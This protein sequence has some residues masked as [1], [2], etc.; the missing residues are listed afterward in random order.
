[1]VPHHVLI[2]RFI[3]LIISEAYLFDLLT[4]SALIYYGTATTDQNADCNDKLGSSDEWTPLEFTDGDNSLEQVLWKIETVHAWVHKLR[5]QIDTVVSKNAAKFS[6]SENLSLLAPFDVQTSAAHSP[7]FSAGNGDTISAGAMY[8]STQHIPEYDIDMA[9]H[10]SVVSS[11]GEAIPVP[12]II[13]STV[14][15]LSAADVTLHQ[16]QFGDSTED[17]SIL[18]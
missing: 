1:M 8:T 7:A 10:E 14:G 12:D 4:L 18:T 13:E 6:S 17:V 3:S 9:M 2:F 5:S 15:L 16:P 11:F